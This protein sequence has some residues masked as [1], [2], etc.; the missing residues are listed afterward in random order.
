MLKYIFAILFSILLQNVHAQITW[1]DT[2]RNSHRNGGDNYRGT[3]KPSIKVAIFYRE[4]IGLEISR[5][6]QKF[7]IDFAFSDSY[8]NYYCVSW[9]ANKNYKSGLYSLKYGYE[10]NFKHLHISMATQAQTD[11]DKLKFYFVPSVGIHYSG[12]IVLYYSR[13]M[14][15]SKTNF[16][17]AS[18]HQFGLSYNFTKGLAKEF[19]KEFYHL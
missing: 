4:N 7:N 6:K 15:F 2:T 5:V 18:K 1:G 14:G 12:T 9:V 10:S 8:T 3:F 11:F 16:I 17:G 19:K 13:P